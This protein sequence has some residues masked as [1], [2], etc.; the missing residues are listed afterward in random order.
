MKFLR[1]GIKPIVCVHPTEMP[2]AR[3]TLSVRSHRGGSR[4]STYV[5]P[6]GAVPARGSSEWRD[7]IEKMGTAREAQLK[8]K[9]VKTRAYEGTSGRGSGA[10][11]E[12]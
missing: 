4:D 9:N 11:T 6:E 7:A 1:V 12:A 2:C 10:E 3:A 8:E 5:S